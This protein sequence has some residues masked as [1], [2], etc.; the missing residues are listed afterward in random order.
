[1]FQSFGNQRVN[2]RT[3]L[4]LDAPL[5]LDLQALRLGAQQPGLSFACK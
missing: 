5:A 1:M 2:R 4:L 3:K